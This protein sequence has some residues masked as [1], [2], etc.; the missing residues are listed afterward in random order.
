M[1]ATWKF[2]ESGLTPRT[3]FTINAESRKREVIRAHAAVLYPE[4]ATQMCELVAQCRARA[5]VSAQD[6]SRIMVENLRR[7]TVGVCACGTSDL[8]LLLNKVTR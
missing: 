7:G 5:V 4:C 2:R 8:D 6:I 3:C 1:S